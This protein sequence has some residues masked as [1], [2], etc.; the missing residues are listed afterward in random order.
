MGVL[1]IVAVILGS[2]IIQL[3]ILGHNAI[4][5]LAPL[6]VPIFVHFT[7]F[8]TLTSMTATMRRTPIR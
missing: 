2:G 6:L 8:T 3:A 7:V 4:D 5:F 1:R